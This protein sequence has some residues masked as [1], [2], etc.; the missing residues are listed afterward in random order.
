M[1][2]LFLLFGI[3]GTGK[4]LLSKKLFDTFV[5]GE[6]SLIIRDDLRRGVLS[7]VSCPK[8]E[9]IDEAV[10]QA[11]RKAISS[12]FKSHQVVICDGC[13]TDPLSMFELLS[14]VETMKE[15]ILVKLIQ[16]GD[17]NSPSRLISSEKLK[18]NDFSSYYDKKGNFKS[19]LDAIPEATMLRKRDEMFCTSRLIA[20]ESSCFKKKADHVIH[21]IPFSWDDTILSQIKF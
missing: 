10:N 18:E 9:E 16:M 13:H 14:L 4:S 12:A 7:R 8:P 17:A 19:K 3:P 11:E 15:K 2:T 5:P 1:K 20:M 21:A 6:A